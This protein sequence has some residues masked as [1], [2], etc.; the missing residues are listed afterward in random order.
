MG[1]SGA[2]RK[3]RITLLLLVLFTVGMNAL[4][5]RLRSTDWDQSLWVVI[6]P[7]IGDDSA[8]TES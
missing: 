2:F 6:Y 7:I 3:I 4:L 8:V 1:S 5:A